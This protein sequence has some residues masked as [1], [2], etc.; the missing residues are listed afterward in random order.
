MKYLL[1]NKETGEGH[2]CEKVTIG[3]FDYCVSDE[4]IKIDTY[5][6]SWETNYTTSPKERYVLY[7]LVSTTNGINPKKVIA[8][9]NPNINVPKVIDEVEEL[10]WDIVNNHSSLK[11]DSEKAIG[12]TS[13]Y[14]GYNKHAETHPYSDENL[15]KALEDFHEMNMAYLTGK[16]DDNLNIEEFIKT[17]KS[18]QPKVIYYQ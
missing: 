15:K 7:N 8:T 16:E 5:Y 6:I 12:F 4:E 18:Q 3:S 1:K 10:A 13:F 11:T 14:E 2:L 9:T 17:W